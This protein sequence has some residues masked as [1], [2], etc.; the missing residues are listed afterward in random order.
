MKKIRFLSAVCLLLLC[1]GGCGGRE[2]PSVS[3]TDSTQPS[4]TQTQPATE[5]PTEEST[6]ATEAAP[7]QIIGYE[8]DVPEGFEIETSEDDRAV[9]LSTLPDDS[10][11]IVYRVEPLD[12]GVPE[13]DEDGFQARIALEQEYE[14]LRLEQTRVDGQP[15]LFA[16]YVVLRQEQRIHIQEY[17]VVGTTE[18]YVFQFSDCTQDEQWLDAFAQTAASINLLMENEGITPDYSALERYSLPCG[19]SLYAAPGMQEQEAPGFSGCIGSRDAIILVMKDDKLERNLTGLTLAD[20]AALVSHA[21]ALEDFTQDNYGNLHVSFYSSDDLGLRY[22]NSLTVKES[23]DSFW[24]IQ[25]TCTASDQAAYDRAFALW[26]TS[27]EGE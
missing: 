24:V 26:A 6:E 8:M 5:P 18:N 22:F 1:L 27:I 10:S 21:N 19:L 12:E 16:D 20:Y 15:A 3:T 23:A 2:V 17:L 13:L 9:Y 14:Q 7:P 11:S 4:T 25:M